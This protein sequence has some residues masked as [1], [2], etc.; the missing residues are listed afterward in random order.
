MEAAEK[1]VGLR[2]VLI[3]L[4][5]FLWKPVPWG[6]W[7]WG[8]RLERSSSTGG[9]GLGTLRPGAATYTRRSRKGSFHLMGK[10]IY[11]GEITYM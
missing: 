6:W 2:Q 1:N 3:R 8:M 11:E 5:F 4:A 7:A 9:I 10:S